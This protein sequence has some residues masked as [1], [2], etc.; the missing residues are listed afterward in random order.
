MD[1]TLPAFRSEPI[2]SRARARIRLTYLWRH[3]ELPN[4]DDPV[5]FNEWVQWRK[6]NDRDIRM[7][8]LADKLRVKNVV[9]DRIGDAWV[10]PTIW[11]GTEL[12]AQPDWHSPFV[13]KSRHGCNQYAF[14][15]DDHADWS[16]IRPKAVR[17][18]KQT[19]GLWLDEWLYSQIPHGLIVEPFIGKG[20]NHPVDFKFYVFGG[21]VEYVQVHLDRGGNHRWILFDR[22]WCRVSSETSDADPPPPVSLAKMI[23]AAEELG[24]GFDFVR[25]D[26]Y[27]VEQKPLFGEMTFYP[28]SGLDPFNPVS[29][30][31]QIGRHWSRARRQA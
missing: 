3:G 14:V 24:A 9:A 22:N 8:V 28:G 13:L 15:F 1:L 10:I 30:D 18:M 16:A 25:V 6:L 19:Y 29:L 7:P 27:E 2:S 20:R 11:H 12:P 23:E 5:R 17:W 21:R 4:L 31:S 26:L